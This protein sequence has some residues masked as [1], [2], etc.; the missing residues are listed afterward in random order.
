MS[1]PNPVQA[2]ERQARPA[3]WLSATITYALSFGGVV[4]A[5]LILAG[6]EPRWSGPS[7]TLL[8]NI[9]G[10]PTTIALALLVFAVMTGVGMRHN[11]ALK[12]L[13]L[14]GVA[15]WYAVFTAAFAWTWTIEPRAG[16]TGPATYGLLVVVT[17]LMMFVRV[18]EATDELRAQA[19]ARS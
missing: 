2:V 17:V 3:N 5:A 10:A 13:G 11:F 18:G 1:L 6:G 8:R 4:Q 15:S 9:P 7:Y 12:T 14:F 19:P 16:S